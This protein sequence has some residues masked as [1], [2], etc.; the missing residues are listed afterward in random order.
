MPQAPR[1]GQ[2]SAIHFDNAALITQ[3]F[4]TNKLQHILFTHSTAELKHWLSHW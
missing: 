4:Y 1:Q 3:D 2:T